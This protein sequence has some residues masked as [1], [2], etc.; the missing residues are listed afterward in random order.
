LQ[1]GLGGA[2]RDLADSGPEAGAEAAE[3]V[4]EGPGEFRNV[5]E[6]EDPVVACEGLEIADRGGSG[7]KGGGAGV[8]QGAENAGGE[9]LARGGR[10]LKDEDGER[11]IGAKGGEQP[12]EAAEPVGAAGEV[13][14]GTEGCQ[15]IAGA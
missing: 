12:G 3:G 10:T 13:E 11:S 7:T 2:A 1:E 4:G 5:V 14:A 15:G 8:D 9:G 6:G